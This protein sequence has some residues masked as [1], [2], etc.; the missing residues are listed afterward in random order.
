MITLLKKLTV[1]QTLFCT[2]LLIASLAIGGMSVARYESEWHRQI[3]FSATLAKQAIYPQTE[4]F[5]SAIASVSY[6]TM[7][8]PTTIQTL[9]NMD[10]VMF[11]EVAGQSD[12]GQ[13]PVSV[14]YVPATGTVWRA[15]LKNTD[16][17]KSSSRV[18]KLEY[19]LKQLDSDD[20]LQS[21]KLN[22]LLNKAR[23]EK[24]LIESSDQIAAKFVMDWHR[25]SQL[26]RNYFLDAENYLLHIVMPLRNQHGGTI[27][28]VF[29]AKELKDVHVNLAVTI[30]REALIAILLALVVVF[31]AVFWIARP[32]KKLASNMNSAAN[33]SSLDGFEELER[34][35]EIGQ[36]ARAY[37]SLL[38]K[39]DQQ[40]NSLR[41][42]S[43]TDTLTGLGSRYKYSNAILPYLQHH[44]AEGRVVGLMVC[45]IDNFKA[46][47][48]I[49]GHMQGDRA[50]IKVANQLESKLTNVDLA[51]RYGGE[52]FVVVCCRRNREE[53]L[54]VGEFLRR[55]V[56]EMAL[57]HQGN[58]NYSVVTVSIGGSFAHVNHLQYA[59]VDFE[60]LIESLFNAADQ[61]M[62]QCKKSGR[63]CSA[64]TEKPVQLS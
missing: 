53:L 15:D 46:Y 42:K 60:R 25:P 9:A 30:L 62:Y 21:R 54:R 16:L 10:N 28:A 36:L 44:L 27:W 64:W 19:L 45:D 52:E 3:H 14:R 31:W 38:L 26:E 58:S 41:A 49:Y 35:D 61:K 13:K 51:F 34:N 29:D 2:H 63:N 39:N 59:S 22:Y 57:S 24:S 50:L 7:T 4:L 48:D 5:S 8:L 40:L 56:E 20:T 18:N 11:V 23:A 32:L 1:S 33:S 55:S 12:V 17:Y 43:D 6:A 37:K 47:N